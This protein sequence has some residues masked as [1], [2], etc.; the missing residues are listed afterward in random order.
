MGHVWR[1]L[2]FEEQG[3]F[4]VSGELVIEPEASTSSVPPR[5]AVDVPTSCVPLKLK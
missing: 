2:G 5:L 1:V 4:G 3:P